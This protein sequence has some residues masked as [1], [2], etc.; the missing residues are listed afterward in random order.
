M[1]AVQLEVEDLHL[2]FGGL[3]VLDGVSFAM[4]RGERL[5]VV[6]PNG[7]GKTSLV[8]CISGF[9]RPQRGRIRFQS[10]EITRLPP[11]RIA[12]L[13][14]GRAF[15]NIEL[16]AGMTVLDN[17]MLAQHRRLGYGL[18]HAVLYYGRAQRVEVEARE[19]AEEVLDFMDLEPYRYAPVGSLPYGIRKRVEVA[20]ALATGP[21]LL[22]LDEPMAGM[23]VEEKEDLARYILEAN[24]E[25]GI[26]VL[27]IEHDLRAVTDL[28]HRVVVLDFGRV[29]AQGPPEAVI[30]DPRVV[31]AYLGEAV[32]S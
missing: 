4:E 23:T 27:L 19:R 30:R 24:E 9:Y 25:R 3:A 22:I 17:L 28:S 13:G 8:N 1:S 11:H 31:D 12:A 32:A 26:S 5:S 10:T 14:I 6:G 16:F 29:I 21:S 15:Q 2:A 18:M 20:R 7:A